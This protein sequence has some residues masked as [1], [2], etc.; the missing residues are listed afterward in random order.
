VS[1]SAFESVKPSAIVW[2][3]VSEIAS[4]AFESVNPSAIRSA[5]VW[6]TV[7]AHPSVSSSATVSV[8]PS[9]TESATVSSVYESACTSAA[10]Q[11][12]LYSPFRL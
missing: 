7:S 3:T 4:S 8:N 2:A 10:F 5:I 1:L 11:A 6:A 12:Q 9:L